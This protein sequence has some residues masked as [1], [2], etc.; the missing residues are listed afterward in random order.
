DGE[1]LSDRG[2]ILTPI[3]NSIRTE[4]AIIGMAGRFPGAICLDAYWRNLSS[5]VES[6]TILDHDEMR[7]EGVPQRILDASKYVRAVAAIDGYDSFDADFFGI[8]ASDA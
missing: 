2:R 7:R 8:R 3:S 4:I 1:G 6:V 5:G